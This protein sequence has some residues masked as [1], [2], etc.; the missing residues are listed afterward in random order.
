LAKTNKFNKNPFRWGSQLK[1]LLAKY[2]LDNNKAQQVGETIVWGSDHTSRIIREFHIMLWPI[3]CNRKELT[4]DNQVQVVAIRS[5]TYHQE[6]KG[7]L[8]WKRCV[9]EKNRLPLEL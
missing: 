1:N 8:F 4:L 2:A 5:L 7:L 6:K 9:K 3:N